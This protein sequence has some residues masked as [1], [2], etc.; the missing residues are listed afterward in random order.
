VKVCGEDAVTLDGDRARVTYTRGDLVDDDTFPES[1]EIGPSPSNLYRM[2][3]EASGRN[4]ILPED[5]LR[6]RS[7]TLDLE[8]DD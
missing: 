6:A 3:L 1:V 8:M 5:L 2:A 7:R 4:E